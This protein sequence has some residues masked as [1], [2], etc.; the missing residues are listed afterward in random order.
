M[1]A[2]EDT[3]FWYRALHGHVEALLNH[4]A[5]DAEVLLD[6]GCGT[7]GLAARL[8]RAGKTVTALDLRDEALAH[9]QARGLK[10]VVQGSVSEL[11]F[12]DA[13]FDVYLSLDVWYHRAVDDE[14]AALEAARVLKPGGVSIV[15]LPAYDGLRGHHDVV[16]ETARRYTKKTL[17]PLL[18]QAGLTLR[19]VTHWNS[20]LFPAIAAARLLG[21]ALPRKQ[22]DASDV[23]PVHPSVNAALLKLLET[24]R[25]LFLSRPLPFGLSLLAVAEKPT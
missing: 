9:C 10:T 25:R 11:P 12:P 17:L 2:V 8:E 14:K 20:A 22:S 15:N 18:S 6:A 5:P 16:V 13:S 7:G 23:A 4:L 3:H 24:E 21:R 1:R 19:F